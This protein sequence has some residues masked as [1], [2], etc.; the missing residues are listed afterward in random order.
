RKLSLAVHKVLRKT[1]VWNSAMLT[2]AKSLSKIKHS[3]I[4]IS[5]P[6]VVCW[7][8][9]TTRIFGLSK[10]TNQNDTKQAAFNILEKSGYEVIVPK[11]LSNTCCGQPFDSKGLYDKAEQK[12]Q[13]VIELLK[14]ASDNF[15]L[16]IVTDAS[17]CSLRINEGMTEAKVY[18][19][20]EFIAKYCLD[21]LKICKIGK[22]AVHQ[23]CS[24]QKAKNQQY[25][26]AIAQAL[27][28]E[29]VIPM[30]VT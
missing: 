28:D 2:G 3:E 4:K 5:K 9:C 29:I 22:L 1:P 11:G 12:R 7:P 8:T 13:Q 27:S 24:T 17:P 20:V 25:M 18:D 19:S 16:P 15:S 10:D 23:T 6:K 30:S 26:L 14:V 21:K